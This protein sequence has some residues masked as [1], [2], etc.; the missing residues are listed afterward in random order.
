MSL[1]GRG[2]I[3]VSYTHLD[4]YKRQDKPS[5]PFPIVN[6]EGDIWCDEFRK[7]SI[8]YQSPSYSKN[9]NNNTVN[10]E[11]DEFSLNTY[12]ID[13]LTDSRHYY[14]GFFLFSIHTKNTIL[15]N[16]CNLMIKVASQPYFKFTDNTTSVYGGVYDYNKNEEVFFTVFDNNSDARLFLSSYVCL[17]NN[18]DEINTSF[19]R[20][21]NFFNRL[22]T[23]STNSMISMHV[24]IILN[25]GNKYYSNSL[26]LFNN[27]KSVT[28]YN[29][30]GCFNSYEG[31]Y[32]KTLIEQEG[33]YLF[34][35]FT[36][37][38]NDSD[39]YTTSVVSHSFID[40]HDVTVSEKTNKRYKN[41][42]ASSSDDE[43]KSLFDEL[44]LNKRWSVSTS[45]SET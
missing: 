24:V 42:S 6:Y 17:I 14:D 25:G 4:V 13:N 11:N 19:D 41:Q 8:L 31:I 44:S 39:A 36:L 18:M 10:D 38:E 43:K 12:L 45:A 27:F 23:I 40:Q 7:K 35:N 30:K 3:T 15:S 26:E 32:T 22:K 37:I 5:T 21:N 34:Y 2:I 20:I 28:K 9:N 29:G 33:S 16:A 1:F